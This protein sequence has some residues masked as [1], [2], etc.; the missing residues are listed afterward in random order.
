MYSSDAQMDNTALV[1]KFHLESKRHHTHSTIP[2]QPNSTTGSRETTSITP[3]DAHTSTPNKL[4]TKNIMNA[5]LCK[6][7]FKKY[8]TYQ[9]QWKKYCA[10]ISVRTA[11]PTLEFLSSFIELFNKRASHRILVSAKYSVAHVLFMEYQYLTHH[12]S[13]EKVFKEV[14]NVKPP[15]PKL[16]FVQD[17]QIMFNHLMQLGDNVQ[18]LDKHLLQEL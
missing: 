10:K 8:L 2:R 1:P 9:N 4:T 18:L 5:S 16:S 12:Y 14:C 6:S 3:E 15:L 13:V 11:T 17:E 7:T